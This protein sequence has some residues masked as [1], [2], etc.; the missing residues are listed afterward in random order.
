MPGRFWTHPSGPRTRAHVERQVQSGLMETTVVREM[1]KIVLF[2][3]GLE[4][5]SPS[6][7]AGYPSEFSLFLDNRYIDNSGA[8]VRARTPRVLYLCLIRPG[9]HP[10][11]SVFENSGGRI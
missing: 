5:N 7:Q 10:K 11:N 6:T 1:L 8:Y 2:I 9:R 4:Y 3:T